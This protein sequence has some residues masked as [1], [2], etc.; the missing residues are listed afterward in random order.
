ML[1]VTDC[2]N[3]NNE[4][5]ASAHFRNWAA[6]VNS[7]EVNYKGY[8]ITCTNE[9]EGLE[10]SNQEIAAKKKFVKVKASF[11]LNRMP[12]PANNTIPSKMNFPSNISETPPSGYITKAEMEMRIQQMQDKFSYETKIREL[13]NTIQ[14]LNDELDDDDND[15][16]D[17]LSGI[18]KIIELINGKKTPS[19]EPVKHALAGAPEPK[20]RLNTAV[21]TLLKHDHNLIIHLEKL[22]KCAVDNPAKFTMILGLLDTHL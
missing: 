3:A 22:A 1:I 6:I 18:N 20:D 11:V 19:D 7:G 2:K 5:E 8:Q 12:D 10:G 4:L 13:E 14:D 16:D 21:K 9:L 17:S 15:N